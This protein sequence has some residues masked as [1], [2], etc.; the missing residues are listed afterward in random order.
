MLRNYNY[1][2]TGLFIQDD[3]KLFKKLF[4]Q[5]GLRLDYQN[6][7]GTFLLPRLAVM[8]NFNKDFYVRAAGGL[9]YKI[10][11]IFSTAS[12]EEGINNILPLASS[13]TA[14]RSIGS[15][16]EFNYKTTIGDEIIATFDQSFFIT[17][18]NHPLILDTT[19]FVNEAKP[20]ITSGFESEVSLHMD[21]WKLFAGY[22][23]VDAQRKYFPEQSFVPLTPK[24]KIVTT[25][26]YEN[27]GNYEVGFEAFYTSSMYRDGDTRSKSY[28]LNGLMIQKYFK[29]VTLV[30]NCENMFD[31]RQTR[32]ENIVIPPFTNPTFRQLYAPI[33]GR[34]F[35]ISLRIKL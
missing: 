35:N 19:Q 7:Y 12:E 27:E 16:L 33:D 21:D 25:L 28:W 10:P 30:V 32:F 14:E 24:H 2:T 3:W 6:Q 23:F 20:I 18:I 15:N 5:E 11:N 8:Y 13:I 17:Q 4:L 22:T 9:G 1:V 31:Q 34:V 29:N 26:V